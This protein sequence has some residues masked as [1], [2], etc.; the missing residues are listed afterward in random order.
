[1]GGATHLAY[2]ILYDENAKYPCSLVN[3]KT[4]SSLVLDNK[5]TE[6]RG[7]ETKTQHKSVFYSISAAVKKDGLNIW[8]PT[9]ILDQY[10][11]NETN[12]LKHL[13]LR[14]VDN[15]ALGLRLNKGHVLLQY[16]NNKQALTLEQLARA[17]LLNASCAELIADY[18]HGL[19][20]LYDKQTGLKARILADLMKLESSH[21]I[22]YEAEINSCLSKIK[23]EYLDKLIP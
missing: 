6:F 13:V 17:G 3:V 23:V 18:E 19:E 7:V 15:F 22:D 20:L 14:E 12:S 11:S 16:N 9:R 21:E 4:S 10:I 1:M 2:Q 5:G 8:V